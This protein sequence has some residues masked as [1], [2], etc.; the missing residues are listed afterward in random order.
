MS[1][2]SEPKKRTGPKNSEDCPSV[3]IQVPLHLTQCDD[4]DNGF[5]TFGMAGGDIY[6]PKNKK[7]KVGSFSIP[8]GAGGI[9]VAT[10][11]MELQVR[12]RGLIDA[13]FEFL[14]KHPE[15]ITAMRSKFQG[16]IGFG[17]G[18]K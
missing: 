16:K 13:I 18:K 6:D 10:D 2:K 11:G 3:M 8:L 4:W 7:R 5:L 15:Q 12:G 1:T 14:E 17:K 9:A